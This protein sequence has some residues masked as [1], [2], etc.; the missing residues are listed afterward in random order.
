MMGLCRSY[1]AL[2]T[3]SRA[4]KTLGGPW[5]MSWRWRW[6][7][8]APQSRRS[9][10]TTSAPRRFHGSG[11]PGVRPALRV[12]IVVSLGRETREVQTPKALV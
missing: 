11:S 2:L 4:G 3:R 1:A 8:V 5:R 7:Q 9:R 10:S 12:R 6:R